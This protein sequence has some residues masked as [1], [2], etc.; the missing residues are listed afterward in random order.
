MGL[1]TMAVVASACSTGS[2][3]PST[4]GVPDSGVRPSLSTGGAAGELMDDAGNA[5][6]S[7]EPDDPPGFSVPARTV[8]D[9]G[10]AR[11]LV[12]GNRYDWEEVAGDF[13]GVAAGP[14]ARVDVTECL[15]LAPGQLVVTGEIELQPDVEEIEL[16][17][18]LGG[19][20]HGSDVYSRGVPVRFTAV[21]SGPFALDLDEIAIEKGRSGS[22]SS[23]VVRSR[24]PER[25]SGGVVASTAAVEE[26]R[27]AAPTHIR[28]EPLLYEA[29]EGSAQALGIGAQL[30][31]PLDTR[32]A[33]AYLAW[34]RQEFGL[35]V[36]W[37]PTD[38]SFRL[39]SV[40]VDDDSLCVH[41][42]GTFDPP[43]PDVE[44]YLLVANYRGCEFANMLRPGSGAPTA[45][46]GWR[47]IDRGPE[48]GV[49]A[50]F[51]GTIVTVESDD[52]S[53]EVLLDVASSLHPLDNVFF[54]VADVVGG[55]AS[56][57]VAIA[58]T[59]GEL[60]GAVERGRFALDDGYIVIATY[61]ETRMYAG[62]ELNDVLITGFTARQTNGQW[63]LRQ[64]GAQGGGDMC[65]KVDTSGA[66][67]E[68]RLVDR[69]A[70]RTAVGAEPDWTI[71]ILR[72]DGWH[73]LRTIAGA[74]F[75]GSTERPV[76]FGD[77]RL[78]ALDGEGR[79]VRC[80]TRLKE[81][82][83]EWSP[84]QPPTARNDL[85]LTVDVSAGLADGQTVRVSGSGFYADSSV[86]LRMCTH[87]TSRWIDFWDCSKRGIGGTKVGPDGS[88]SKEV[89][90]R[91]SFTNFLD[92]RVD[93]TAQRCVIRADN[94]RAYHRAGWV[95]VAFAP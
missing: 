56:L 81:P 23:P 78:R 24:D 30:D 95:E 79:V 9:P 94:D 86:T 11:D 50:E 75:R 34:G 28:T 82:D 74:H 38:R 76:G 15:L 72:D 77:R 36:V 69:A 18:D 1:V 88:F 92:E 68:G 17:L 45:L 54:G 43:P 6:L 61:V 49:V 91:T 10:V 93:C 47:F 52:A 14:G 67:S 33:W 2:A 42:H 80:S 35:P 51:D 84:W 58:E 65:L 39:Q 41:T 3:P 7:I 66:T 48:R 5:P 31:D 20:F 46:E 59:L 22:V 37:A 71:Q 63:Y 4:R 83:E 29:P 73:N 40:S 19:G 89:T 57:D 64:T 44:S 26:T 12:F 27:F 25:C 62:D 13:E 60:P 8:V 70:W 21:G 85:P 90:V 87:E 16:L 32:V 53:L 55:D